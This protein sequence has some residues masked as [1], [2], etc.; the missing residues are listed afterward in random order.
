MSVSEGAGL[1]R[2]SPT[3]AADV[4]EIVRGMLSLQAQAAT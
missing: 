1:E 3:E 4:D 2:K